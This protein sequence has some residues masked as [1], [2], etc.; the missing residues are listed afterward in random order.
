MG[1]TLK[2]VQIGC[3][4][5]SVYTMRYVAEKGGEMVGAYDIN[6]D[7]IGKDICTITGGKPTGVLIENVG[8]L[9]DL[10]RTKI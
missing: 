4:K 8:D 9:K 7:I 6:P 10:Q 1:K 3:G 2:V 5:M